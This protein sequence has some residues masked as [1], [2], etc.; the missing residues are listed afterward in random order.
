MKFTT[1]FKLILAGAFVLVS[2]AVVAQ[3]FNS[4][5][6]A[7]FQV[8]QRK[9][10]A[11]FTVNITNLL[12]GNCTAGVP[13]TMSFGDGTPSSQNTF[14][15]TYTAPGTY[16]LG[17][18]TQSQGLDTIHI[19]VVPNIEPNFEIYACSSNR[20]AIRVTD[21][22]YA[23]YLIDFT[24]DG[25]PEYTLPF[26]NNI[27]TGSFTYAP[28][29][30]YTASVK[31]RNL[32]AA[33]NCTAKTQ[34]F[35]SIAT[36]PAPA[37]T[38]LTSV[39]VNTATLDLNTATN[40]LYRLEVATNN[41]STFQVFNTLY[42]VNTITG[43]SLNLDQNYYCFRL[44]AYDPCANASTY[45]NIICSNRL[46]VTPQSDVMIVTSNT[47]GP[48]VNYTIQRN[49]T[50][51]TTVAANPFNDVD[52]D[53]KTDYCYQVTTN[54]GAGR[55]SISLEKCGTSFSNLIPT[56]IDDVTATVDA[57][58]AVFTWQQDPAFIP[59]EYYI[60]RR[61][62]S[63]PYQ[64]Y[65]TTPGSPY[66]DTGYSTGGNFCY[67]INYKDQCDN[68]SSPGVTSCPVQLFGSLSISNSISLYWSGYKGWKLGVKDYVIEKYN[69]NGDMLQ[70]IILTPTD[71]VFLDDAPDEENQYVRYRARVRANDPALTSAYS[72]E[73]EFIR[74]ANLYAPTAFTPNNDLLNDSFQVQG[75][76][77]EKI[78][79][80]VF[81]RWGALV[82]ST[83]KN[84]PWDGSSSGKVMPPT[85]YV[86][87]VDITDKA[88]RTFT[89]EGTV[90]LIR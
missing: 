89:E 90:A 49:G 10:C 21:N 88:G 85:T 56:A 59:V 62:G 67:L 74:N 53:C 87:K 68:N 18:L 20:A 52:I 9:G 31:G 36:L 63:A 86:W 65:T 60:T 7:Q 19:T 44:G 42:G 12:A 57:P 41:A 5:P 81:D 32:N 24:N 50:A 30:T 51:Y 58:G 37:I 28:P 55:T 66:T 14:I 3:P 83:E 45:S 35:T 82:F 17:V 16:V 47:A 72:N 73:L 40:V 27:L 13:C 61:S 77:I 15:H 38:K 76:Y 39:D 84:E 75:Q 69:V 70:T 54:Y 23:Q 78:K 1:N 8:D 22:N 4:K 80:R 34:P 25:T 79:L 11:S 29:G 64:F 46:V 26:S 43:S 6:D 48:I 2:S 33:D 71:T